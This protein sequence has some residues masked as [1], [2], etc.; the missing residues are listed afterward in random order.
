VSEPDRRVILVKGFFGLAGRLKALIE[1]VAYA[2]L[3]DRDVFVEWRDK[4]YS[5]DGDD[6]FFKLFESRNI[7]PWPDPPPSTGIVPARW[8]P[9]VDVSVEDLGKVSKERGNGESVTDFEID[10]T[11]YE[12]DDPVIVVFR[13]ARQKT[14]MM[15]RLQRIQLRALEPGSPVTP[16]TIRPAIGRRDFPGLVKEVMSEEI[17]L[18][19]EIRHHVDAFKKK[20]F[21]GCVIGVHVRYTD[22]I[23]DLS[24]V[25]AAL[26]EVL[27]KEPDAKIFLASD[28][29][30]VTDLFKNRYPNVI[31][32]DIT[33]SHEVANLHRSESWSA[34]ALQ[35]A[36]DALTD[37]YL[38]AAC[39]Y[40]L[41]CRDMGFSVLPYA[42]SDIDESRKIAYQRGADVILAR[43]QS[44]PPL[45]SV[46]VPFR[47]PDELDGCL[48]QLKSQHY[49]PEAFRVTVF[50]EFGHW[51]WWSLKMR[52]PD[53]IRMRGATL[54]EA[55]RA[56]R[57]KAIA[58]TDAGFDHPENWIAEGL[59]QLVG[60]PLA[61]LVYGAANGD[62]DRRR[63]FLWRAMMMDPG[64]D[65][66]DIELAPDS[67]WGLRAAA[68]GYRH[69]PFAAP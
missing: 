61:G 29:Q 17:V 68:L 46:L 57:G 50:G 52:F 63:F 48:R 2:E 20:H 69:R 42:L 1:S 7:R 10:V 43:W 55:V 56:S 25:L 13:G 15:E 64:L 31:A 40:L 18:R 16:R 14:Q 59:D 19:P 32:R 44:K 28:S 33:R 39:D 41:Y 53:V 4:S 24:R 66:P 9:F 12:G 67:A 45:V 36:V 65:L 54:A 6:V 47:P 21:D 49:P 60:T 62:K 37:I 51:D 26:D 35:K 34:D 22:K 5:P 30:S 58:V 27:E 8:A 3:T 11:K 23:V 38:L